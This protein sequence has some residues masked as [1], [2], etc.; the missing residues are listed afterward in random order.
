MLGRLISE[1]LYVSVLGMSSVTTT[2]VVIFCGP[3][4]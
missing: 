1:L 3:A 2:Y 4:V